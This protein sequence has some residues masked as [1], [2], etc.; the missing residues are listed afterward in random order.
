MASLVILSL[1]QDSSSQCAQSLGLHNYTQRKFNR[2]LTPDPA[3]QF[4]GLV[5]LGYV[6]RAQRRIGQQIVASPDSHS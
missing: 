5:N 1:C 2:G 3:A 4:D 6:I